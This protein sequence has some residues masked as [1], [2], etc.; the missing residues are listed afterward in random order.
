[1]VRRR[2]KRA[3]FEAGPASFIFLDEVHK[4]PRWDEDVKHLFDT[5]PVRVMLTGSSSVLVTKGGRE[6]LAGRTIMTDFP[7]FQ[8]RE[9]LEAWMPIAQRLGPPREVRR[10]ISTRVAAVTFFL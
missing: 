5:F 7:T 2:D 8:F 10:S 1:M 9:V 3:A 6:S 4:L